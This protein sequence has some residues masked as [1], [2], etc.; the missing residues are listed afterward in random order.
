MKNKI[1]LACATVC[2]GLT[3][4]SSFAM[5]DNVPLQLD[6]YAI[7]MN[8]PH[9][10]AS[11]TVN[12]AKSHTQGSAASCVSYKDNSSTISA[13]DLKAGP[14]SIQ[15][16]NADSTTVKDYSDSI[17]SSDYQNII[18]QLNKYQHESITFNY[19]YSQGT[20]T[21]NAAGETSDIFT[22]AHHEQVEIC[23]AGYN[24]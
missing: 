22:T 11:I 20:A 3:G 2:L 19:P 5:A 10:D 24:G 8:I 18:S 6:T 17:P 21:C 14:V 16:H 1:A 15:L 13:A 9:C 23:F 12:G 4:V 7:P